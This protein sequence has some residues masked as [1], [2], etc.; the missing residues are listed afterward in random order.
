[1]ERNNRKQRLY[2]GY[3]SNYIMVYKSNWLLQ[4]GQAQMEFKTRLILNPINRVYFKE[5]QITRV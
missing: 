4:L 5:V 1:M 3:K 2:Y